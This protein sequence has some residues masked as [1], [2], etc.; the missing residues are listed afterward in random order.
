MQPKL[1]V[2]IQ[3]EVVFIPFEDVLKELEDA[4]TI[5]VN[6]H[7][8]RLAGKFVLFQ[9]DPESD[10]E[11]LFTSQHILV[12]NDDNTFKIEEKSIIEGYEIITPRTQMFSA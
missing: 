11:E 9:A 2:P 8:V 5:Y 10:F 1:A 3:N 7:R 6:N 4:N 12:M